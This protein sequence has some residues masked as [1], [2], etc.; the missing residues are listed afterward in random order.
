MTLRARFVFIIICMTSH[1]NAQDARAIIQ[2]YIDTVSGGDIRNWNAITT[3]YEEGQSYYSHNDFEQKTSLVN[4][5]APSYFRTWIDLN[6]DKTKRELFMDSSFEMRTSAFYFFKD[7]II[8]LMGTLPPMKRGALDRDPYLSPHLPVYISNILEH[9][10]SAELISVK[11]LQAGGPSLYELKLTAKGKEYFL[12][13]NVDT[14]LLEYYNITGSGDRSILAAVDEYHQFG[15]LLI[16]MF[17]SSM[18]NN[19]VY[20]WSRKSKLVLN[21]EID[22]VILEFKEK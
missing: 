18:K 19:V 16:P 12:F 1:M 22:P 5:D 4:P 6:A 11:Q 10:R 13:I 3:M 2:H 9:S 14:F 20:Y 7:K 15:N 17:E 21:P 8:I